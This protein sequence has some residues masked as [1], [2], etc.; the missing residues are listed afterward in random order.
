MAGNGFGIL[1]RKMPAVFLL[2][3]AALFLAGKAAGGGFL[4][5]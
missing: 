5:V 4:P 2:L 1:K 3:F